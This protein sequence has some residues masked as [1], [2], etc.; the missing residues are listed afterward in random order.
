ME[1]RPTYTF[2][3]VSI[4]ARGA[5]RTRGTGGP[6]STRGTSWT[7]LTTITLFVK[8]KGRREYQSS[9]PVWGW[10]QFKLLSCHFSHF[11]ISSGCIYNTYKKLTLGPA[12][13]SRPGAPSAPGEPYGPRTKAE[14]ER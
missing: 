7:T 10:P 13:P 6:R 8:G 1:K 5:N 3:T 2:T 9:E 4:L 12:E 14:K 11:L